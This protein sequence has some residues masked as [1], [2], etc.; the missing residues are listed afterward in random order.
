M[1]ALTKASILL[2]VLISTA[3]TAPAS[4]WKAQDTALEAAYFGLHLIDWSQT[5][6]IREDER[7]IETNV[8]LGRHPS[9][10][11]VDRY[12]LGAALLHI[13]AAWFLPGKWRERFQIFTIGM[14]VS[15]T[16]HNFS[17]GI[18]TKF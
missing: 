5:R 14:E 10:T 6:R 2:T 16:A 11:E 3:T 13:A 8:F 15:I 4:N 18:K 7:L 12:F 17:A 9:K 1:R